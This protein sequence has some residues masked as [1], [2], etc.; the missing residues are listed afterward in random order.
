[1]KFKKNP[2]KYLPQYGAWCAYAMGDNG[3][4]VS[5]NPETYKIVDG[6]LYLFYNKLFVNT[7]KSWNKDEDRIKAKADANWTTVLTK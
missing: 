6:K 5:V 1:M 7:L 2:T 4:K 3:D